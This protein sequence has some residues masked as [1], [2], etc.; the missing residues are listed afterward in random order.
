MLAPLLSS[1][2]PLTYFYMTSIHEGKISA[3]TER[4][5]GYIR[6][7]GVKEDI[8]F[9]GMDLGGVTFAELRVGDALTYSITQSLKGPY[10]TQVT[11]RVGKAVHA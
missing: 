8:F 11:R 9:D 1:L 10:A 7:T 3:L 5:F 6:E 4:G 2:Y